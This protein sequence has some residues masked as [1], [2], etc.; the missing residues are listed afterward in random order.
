MLPRVEPRD[1][2]EYIRK[3]R[4]CILRSLPEDLADLARLSA[5][6]TICRG[7]EDVEVDVERVSDRGTFG[8]G[9]TKTRMTL[10]A[11][12]AALDAGENLY[13]TTQYDDVED[14][15]VLHEPLRSMVS[16]GS[17]SLP[18]VPAL[19]A[20]RVTAKVN[21]WIGRSKEGTSSGF[22]H[23]FHDN[24]YMLLQGKKRF[25]IFPPTEHVCRAAGVRGERIH[26]NGVIAYDDDLGADGV[27]L[28]D[29]RELRVE[30]RR[31]AVRDD[32][33]ASKAR[34]E[35]AY[36]ELLQS[37][38]ADEIGDDGGEEVD[39]DESDDEDGNDYGEAGGDEQDNDDDDDEGGDAGAARGNDND[40]G[41]DRIGEHPMTP[42]GPENDEQNHGDDTKPPSFS[43]L[44]TAQVTHLLSD[45]TLGGTEVELRAGEALYLPASYFHEVLSSSSADGAPHVAVNYWFYPPDDADLTG[46]ADSEVLGELKHRLDESFAELAHPRKR[47][48]R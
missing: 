6:A 17:L 10:S 44:T 27:T 34:L 28:T 39:D 46:Y 30:A 26:R 38:L 25:R 36:D 5:P 42:G 29:R 8:T 2:L 21:L 18:A 15:Q 31:R 20:G 1:A 45:E 19:M 24:L 35:E 22:H 3:R 47:A 16:R 7:V 9:K 11:F 4:P 48:K 13:L 33:E 32:D 41:G 37:A 40:N 14:D 23:D 12:F 43:S